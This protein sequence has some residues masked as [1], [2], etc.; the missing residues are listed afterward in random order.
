[1]QIVSSAE[2][3]K[4]GNKKTVGKPKAVRDAPAQAP[5]WE[6]SNTRKSATIREPYT[7]QFGSANNEAGED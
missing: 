1:M 2:T 6:E 3:S 4:E 7:I 5:L